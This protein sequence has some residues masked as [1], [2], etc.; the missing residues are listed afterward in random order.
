MAAQDKVDIKLNQ[1]LWCLVV[2]FAALGAALHWGLH[3]LFWPAYI[4]MCGAG[5]LVLISC[6]FYTW[7][8]C[9]R[10]C[11]L[12]RRLCRGTVALDSAQRASGAGQAK[13]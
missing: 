1:N 10:K 3:E 5:I 4:F 11:M 13:L 6:V 2:G 9:V 12:A 8:Y 7:H